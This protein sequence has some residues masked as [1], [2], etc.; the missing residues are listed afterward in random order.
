MMISATTF[1]V[2]LCI[3]ST[4]GVVSA[5]PFR[6]VN[7][8]REEIS[9]AMAN[10]P[11]EEATFT[12]PRIRIPNAS[13]SVA[14]QQKSSEKSS[15]VLDQKLSPLDMVDLHRR[16][17]PT[18]ESLTKKEASFLEDTIRNA[19]EK[20]HKDRDSIAIDTKKKNN[21]LRGSH[22]SP[23]IP[24]DREVLKRYEQRIGNSF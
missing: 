12:A 22:K 21:S 1:L 2:P 13:A 18:D 4:T 14:A 8:K 24:I 11:N 15:T 3:V 23:F 6:L 16:F 7:G 19:Y 9:K 20:I 17:G 5:Q 10:K